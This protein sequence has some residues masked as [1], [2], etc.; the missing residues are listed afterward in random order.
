[1]KRSI[2]AKADKFRV[3]GIYADA[4]TDAQKKLQ[5][6]PILFKEIN[7]WVLYVSVCVSMSDQI[8]VFEYEKLN[9]TNCFI[10]FQ[11]KFFEVSRHLK[12]RSSTNCEGSDVLEFNFNRVYQHVFGRVPQG[13]KNHQ[14]DDQIKIVKVNISRPCEKYMLPSLESDESCK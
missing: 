13:T 11:E 12:F 1:M 3:C 2:T 10:N 4:V 9:V 14:L 7:T 5:S 6:Q 8:E